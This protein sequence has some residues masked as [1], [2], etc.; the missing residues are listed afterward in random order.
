MLDT[1]KLA[2]HERQL[3]DHGYRYRAECLRETL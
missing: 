1:I 3:K 2:S